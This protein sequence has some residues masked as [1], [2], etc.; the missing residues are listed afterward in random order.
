MAVLLFL[1][2]PR[3]EGLYCRNY[4][5]S[6]EV[7]VDRGGVC[8]RHDTHEGEKDVQGTQPATTGCPAGPCFNLKRFTMDL[9]VPGPLVI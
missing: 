8:P 9:G 4:K 5:H 2:S 1:N 6:G 3:T 7:E